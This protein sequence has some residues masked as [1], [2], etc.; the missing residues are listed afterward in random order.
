MELSVFLGL[1]IMLGY[2][3]GKISNKAKFPA[4]IGFMEGKLAVNGRPIE[5]LA[6]KPILGYENS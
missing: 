5:G 6:G 3:G 4:V 1:A 2:I